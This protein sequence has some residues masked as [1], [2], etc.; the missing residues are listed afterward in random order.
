LKRGRQLR[1]IG[2]RGSGIRGVRN[3]A[4]AAHQEVNKFRF[5]GFLYCIFIRNISTP[6]SFKIMSG[7]AMGFAS[8]DSS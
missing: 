1:G 3:D 8:I 4:R 5:L 6:K 7:F 2:V